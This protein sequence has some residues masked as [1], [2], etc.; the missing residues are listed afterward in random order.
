MMDRW[1]RVSFSIPVT[2]SRSCSA[3]PQVHTP[4]SEQPPAD[5]VPQLSHYIKRCEDLTLGRKTSS[6]LFPFFS[7]KGMSIYPHPETVREDDRPGAGNTTTQREHWLWPHLS[8]A[9]RRSTKVIKLSHW[10]GC[11][12]VFSR[13]DGGWRWR[14]QVCDIYL[15]EKNSVFMSVH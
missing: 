3:G 14:G 6:R 12:I 5:S 1:V 15:L 2:P 11:R 9:F 7:N 4:S 8:E 13:G 10:Q